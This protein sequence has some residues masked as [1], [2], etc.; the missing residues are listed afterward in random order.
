MLATNNVVSQPV[1]FVV[2]VDLDAVMETGEEERL[3]PPMLPQVRA[4]PAAGMQPA[5]GTQPA[6]GTQLV[7]MQHAPGTQPAGGNGEETQLVEVTGAG[8]EQDKT[9]ST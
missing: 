1:V 3:P 5:G 4:E 8:T 6:P 9:P 2:Q 7:G